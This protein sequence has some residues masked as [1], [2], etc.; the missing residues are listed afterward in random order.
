MRISDWSSDVCSSDLVPSRGRRRSVP[1]ADVAALQAVADDAE[2]ASPRDAPDFGAF[3]AFR[4]DHRGA[5]GRQELREQAQLGGAVIRHRAVIVEMVAA[6]I[7]EGGGPDAHAVEP[8][9]GGA[10]AGGLTR[11]M[12]DR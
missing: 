3:P 4:V 1:A 5:V 6:D 7:G 8:V 11:Q 2:S 12:L 10:V 9:S